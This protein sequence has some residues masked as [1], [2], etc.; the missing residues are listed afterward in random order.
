MRA[1]CVNASSNFGTMVAFDAPRELAQDARTIVALDRKDEREAELCVVGGVERRQARK[2]VGRALRK[3]R[4]RLLQRRV[5]RELT[6]QGGFAREFR[7]RANQ[8]RSA[9]VAAPNA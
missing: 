5:G 7:V 2:L 8:R 9:Q 4:A 3:A 1:I 6:A